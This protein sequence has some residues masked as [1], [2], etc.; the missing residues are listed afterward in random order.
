MAT[1]VLSEGQN[2]QDAAIVVNYDLPWTII[3]LIQRA[4]RVDRIGQISPTV[5]VYS[6]LPQTGVEDVIQLRKR[7]G[8][9][10]RENAEVFGSDEQFFEDDL[11]EDDLKGL[12]DGTRSLDDN[13]VDE[14]VDWASQALAIWE[15]ATEE[16]Q[17]RAMSLP[18]VTYSTRPRRQGD[19]HGGILVYTRTSRGIDG[20]AFTEPGPRR[21][22]P[23]FHS[24][25]GPP[26]RGH[27]TQRQA[28]RPARRSPSTRRAGRLDRAP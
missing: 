7:I 3:R 26:H 24:V 11:T 9:R 27:R 22:N 4:G 28:A 12:F 6:F 17:Q 18:D 21:R 20:L 13:E 1:D 25:R 15:S 2:L 19:E 5:E 16:Q 23:G 10:L 14:D 8:Q